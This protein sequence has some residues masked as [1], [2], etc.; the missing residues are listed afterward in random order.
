MTDPP[1]TDP[2]DP[3]PSDP[4]P[5]DP[6]P[7]DIVR[8][9]QRL[10]AEAA[11]LLQA[12]ASAETAAQDAYGHIVEPQVQARLAAMPIDALQQATERALRV[13]AVEDAGLR[14]VLSVRQA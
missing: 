12:L 10:A 11:F 9:A 4:N 3:D 2:S 7:S 5:S 1:G 13:G 14:T 6:N 8:E